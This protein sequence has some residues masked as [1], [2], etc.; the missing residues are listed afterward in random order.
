[1]N[2]A[3][4][5]HAKKRRPRWLPTPTTTR[6]QPGLRAVPLRSSC[7]CASPRFSRGC[8]APGRAAPLATASAPRPRPR[9]PCRLTSTLCPASASRPRLRSPPG[10]VLC[11]T[12]CPS[13]ARG[14]P[15]SSSAPAARIR[16][17]VPS[18]RQRTVVRSTAA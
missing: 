12:A 14:A 1:M 7:G 4:Q 5:F 11:R 6:R 18:H 13:A 10:H 8:A 17:A 9:P 3:L 16:A 15:A 2:K